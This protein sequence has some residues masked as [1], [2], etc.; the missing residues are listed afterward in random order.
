M[1]TGRKP[2]PKAI[3]K[4]RGSQVRGPHSRGGIDAPPGV[5]AAPDYLCDI[6]RA[7]WNRIVPMLESSR[8]MSL[9]H[10]HT[11]AAYCDSLADMVKADRE[12]REHGATFMDDKGRVM[13]HPAWYRKKD[14]RLHMLRFAEQFGLTASALA[15][16]S[17]VD[18]APQEDDEDRLMFG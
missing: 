9:R 16:V 14:A 7:E 4:M 11:L 10:Q 12:L 18:N 13:N 17:A 8:V 5:P 15:R 6:G 2:T 1:P 3:L